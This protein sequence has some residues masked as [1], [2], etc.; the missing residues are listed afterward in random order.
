MSRVVTTL[1]T[2]WFTF[3]S[4]CLF[5]GMLTLIIT[6]DLPKPSNNGLGFYPS[7]INWV[8]YEYELG[9]SKEP[10]TKKTKYPQISEWFLNFYIRNNRTE[11]R[12]GTQIYKNI[13]YIYTT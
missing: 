3:I 5:I 8:K 10:G 7:T 2:S 13:N 6:M 12:M 11:N 4:T 9:L 1:A